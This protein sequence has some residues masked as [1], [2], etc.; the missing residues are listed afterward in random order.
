MGKTG[1][2]IFYLQDVAL[3]QVS[4][5]DV[6]RLGKELIE[7]GPAEKDLGLLF[8]EKLD[9]NQQCAFTGWKTNCILVCI[10]REVTCR[11]REE[12]VPFYS[13]HMKPHQEYCI[14]TWGLQHK[15][16]MGLLE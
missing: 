9:T 8:Y 2:I 16:D 15:K 10:K 11:E 5:R 7:S 3:G 6:Y 14:Q 13:A 4:P 1:L 12:I